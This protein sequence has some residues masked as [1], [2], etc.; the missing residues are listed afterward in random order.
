MAALYARRN[1]PIELAEPVTVLP[2][3][4]PVAACVTETASP[5]L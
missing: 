5:P 1:R 4:G 2:T 3:A